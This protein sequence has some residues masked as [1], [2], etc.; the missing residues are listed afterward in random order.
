[1]E[2]VTVVNANC[3]REESLMSQAFN[4]GE[5]DGLEGVDMRGS[6]YFVAGPALDAYFDGYQSG[7]YLRNALSGG[8]LLGEVE[9]MNAVLNGLRHVS[10]K[11]A[12]CQLADQ[13]L[14]R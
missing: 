2:M 7:M 10:G 1:M 3:N 6:E 11:P 5:E 4:F 12:E 13:W 14:Y 9:F 8:E